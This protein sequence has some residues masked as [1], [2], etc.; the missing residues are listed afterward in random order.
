MPINWA[1]GV[2]ADMDNLSYQKAND[3]ER[4]LYEIGTAF[5]FV[6]PLYTAD[7]YITDFGT[8]DNQ[9]IDDNWN[10]NFTLV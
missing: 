3:I 7:G 2:P 4:V 10:F 8:I 5:R 1:T 9:L 6:A